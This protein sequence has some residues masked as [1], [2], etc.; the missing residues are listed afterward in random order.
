MESYI[1]ALKA[2]ELAQSQVQL[3]FTPANLKLFCTETFKN[4][5]IQEDVV[6][7]FMRMLS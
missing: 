7:D 4:L 6:A 2:Y 1:D 5:K 3:P